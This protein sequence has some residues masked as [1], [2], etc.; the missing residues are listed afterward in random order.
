MS[1]IAEVSVDELRLLIQKLVGRMH[2][3]PREAVRRMNDGEW[4]AVQAE[5]IPPATSSELPVKRPEPPVRKEDLPLSNAA[6]G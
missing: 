2:V 4:I 5:E 6:I 3:A 1:T